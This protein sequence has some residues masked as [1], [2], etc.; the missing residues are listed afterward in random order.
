MGYRK[1][2]VENKAK[3]EVLT[4][5]GLKDF[6]NAYQVGSNTYAFETYQDIEGKETPVWVEVKLV[7]KNFIT[8]ARNVAYDGFIESKS[9]EIEIAEK[10]EKAKAKAEKKAK[11]IKADEEMREKVRL[12]KQAK[13]LGADTE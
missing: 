6:E 9:Y 13:E 8:N 2:D 1:S 4:E 10:K 11:K 12:E 7:A 5:I 3:L